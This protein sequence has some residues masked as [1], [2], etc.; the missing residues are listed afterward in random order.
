MGGAIC[1]N[2]ASRAGWMPCRPQLRPR[3]SAPAHAGNLILFHFLAMKITTQMRLAQE[4]YIS[5]DQTGGVHV[6]G[7]G[8]RAPSVFIPQKVFLKSFC[9][10]RFSHKS[11]NLFSISV[12]VKE[13][14]TDLWGI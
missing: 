7:R 1:P 3:E 13:K 2:V 9:E 4:T 10:S 14:L 6:A 8:E 12:I 11:V 5:P